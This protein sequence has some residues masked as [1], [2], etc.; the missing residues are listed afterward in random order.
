MPPAALQLSDDDVRALLLLQQDYCAVDP[1]W[2]ACF[3]SRISARTLLF[4]QR[5]V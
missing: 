1:S 4:V 2:C 5:N 3:Q